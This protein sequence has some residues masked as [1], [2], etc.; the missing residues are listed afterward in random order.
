MRRFAL[1]ACV[2]L[3]LGAGG[4]AVQPQGGDRDLVDDWVM[5][6]EAKV[7][8]PAVG[9][10]WTTDAGRIDDVIDAPSRVVQAPCDSQHAFETVHVGHFT[11][12]LADGGVA[13]SRDEMADAYTE[14]N[15]A[16]NEF[17]GAAWQ[18]GRVHL[19]ISAPTSAQWAG[20]ARFFRCDVGALRTEL[21][22]L[23]PGKTTL[24]DSLKPGGALLLGCGV[25]VGVAD[26]GWDDITPAACTTPHDTEFVGLV[27]SKTQ[28]YP[29]DSKS[30]DA[31]FGD[32]CEKLL[33]SYTGMSTSHFAKELDLNYGYWMA[34]G[35][36]EWKAGDHT[37]RCYAMLEKKKLSRSLKGVG[38]ISI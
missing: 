21:G 33:L 2:L 23:E 36:D 17:L 13:P 37:A 11:G 19:L 34:A 9:D 26:D 27:Q 38:N 4:C 3:L 5:L 18:S 6:A 28:V 14:C 10:C 22:Y 29:Q 30:F 12:K 35:S 7:P 15:T 16:A 20:E 31:A 25:Q 1:A 24:K 32:S 8:E